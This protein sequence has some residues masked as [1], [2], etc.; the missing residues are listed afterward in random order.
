MKKI[1]FVAIVA[2]VMTFILFL[3]MSGNRNG[4]QGESIERQQV[5]VAATDIAPLTIITED[6]I[7]LSEIEVSAVH[8]D[9][10]QQKEDAVGKIAGNQI[11]AGEQFLHAK[12]NQDI[13]STGLA[14]QVSEGNRAITVL[15]ETDTG[16]GNMLR[17]GNRVDL[18]T[19]IPSDLPEDLMEKYNNWI[20]NYPEYFALMNQLMDQIGNGNAMISSEEDLESQMGINMF[21]SGIQVTKSILLYQNLRVLAVDSAYTM[22]LYQNSIVSPENYISV[23]LEVS[24]EQAVGI[25]LAETGGAIRMILRNQEDDQI[26]ERE[27]KTYQDLMQGGQEE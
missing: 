20:T 7:T 21:M 2:G 9:A 1:K 6:M 14:Y 27:E 22:E 19:T 4:D 25:H 12:L 23:T 3:V 15:T 16:I 24:P 11:Y 10:I 8:P 26:V 13:S 18:V 17:P 5:L